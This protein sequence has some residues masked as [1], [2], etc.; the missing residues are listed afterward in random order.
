MKSE[1][2]VCNQERTMLE[3]ELNRLLEFTLRMEIELD[4]ALQENKTR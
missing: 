1:S 4:L 2:V 3:A